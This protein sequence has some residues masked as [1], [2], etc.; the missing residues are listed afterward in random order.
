MAGRGEDLVEAGHV[1]M[2]ANVVGEAVVLL[3]FI[4]VV[5]ERGAAFGHQVGVRLEEEVDEGGVVE[6]AVDVGAHAAAVDD[7][8]VGLAVGELEKRGDLCAVAGGGAAHVDFVAGESGGRDLTEGAL[9]LSGALVA[10]DGGGDG[11]QT[12]AGQAGDVAF[13]AVGVADFCAHQLVAA[14]DAEHGCATTAST[15][16]SLCAAAAA[17]VGEVGERG[18]RTGQDDDVSL[19]DV[20]GSGGIEQVDARVVLQRVEVGEVGHVAQQDDGHVQP[21]AAC[22][23]GL[24]GELHAVLLLDVD[25]A[26]VGDDT[27]HGHAADVF[28][29]SAAVVE[30]AQ[31]AAE[32]VDDDALDE[33][34]VL[35]GLQGDA[36][37]GRGED[38]AAVDVGHEQHVGSGMPGHGQVDKVGV[39]QV[40]FGH[41]ARALHDDGIILRGQPVEGAAHGLPQL[42]A[43]LAAEV[44][45]GRAVAHGPAVEHDL[46]RA[47]RLR[48]EQHGVHVRRAGHA[49]RLGL[50]GLRPTNL[51]SVGRGV[52]VE[53]HVLRLERCRAVAVL[54]EDAAQGGRDDALA[55]VAARAGEHQRVQSV[56]PHGRRP[57]SSIAV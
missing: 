32:L 14:A 40:Q 30:E 36:A 43:A 29:Q 35:L 21:S 56:S 53:R 57:P 38:A 54:T 12:E 44:L 4:G 42:F 28:E 34:A 48:F 31:V 41:A 55:H 9:D 39:A 22:G 26:E 7:V 16:D 51:Q 8:A 18:L 6:D 23:G 37:I 45:P 10:A 13:E 33:P 15:D 25:V 46:R 2:A 19:L 17:Q 47:V 24:E 50:H 20:V 5:V 3:F 52:R 27:E 49:R 11:Q 1:E